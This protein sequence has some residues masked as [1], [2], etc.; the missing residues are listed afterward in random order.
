M[1]GF[2]TDLHVLLHAFRKHLTKCFLLGNYPRSEF[3]MPTF[4]NTLA[5]P[6]SYASK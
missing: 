5:V 3:Y 4:W 2:H 1:D 6:S